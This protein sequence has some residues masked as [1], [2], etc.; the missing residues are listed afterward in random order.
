MTSMST[1]K[2]LPSEITVSCVLHVGPST[3]NTEI[4]CFTT[5][6]WNKVKLVAEQR[7]KR[8]KSS[9]YSDICKKI[10][11]LDFDKYVGF[12]SAYLKNFTA[13]SNWLIP[14]R[15]TLHTPPHHRRCLFSDHP[16]MFILQQ[17]QAFYHR[18]ASFYTFTRESQIIWWFSLSIL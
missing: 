1:G 10:H 3:D 18:C 11:K 4:K 6:S 14:L 8:F 16:W 9:K 13:F 5:E 7:L 2:G 15:Q 17:E 12:H